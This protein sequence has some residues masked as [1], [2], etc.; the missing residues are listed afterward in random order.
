[1]I[2]SIVGLS[3]S[4]LIQVKSR[5]D[6]ADKNPQGHACEQTESC[7]DVTLNNVGITK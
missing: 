3:T 6:P 4:F 5:P 1:M 2:A 7:H